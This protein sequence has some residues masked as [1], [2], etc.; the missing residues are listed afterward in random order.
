MVIEGLM[1]GIFIAKLL[2]TAQNEKAQ[3]ESAVEGET[4]EQAKER[5]HRANYESMFTKS[6]MPIF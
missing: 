4:E 1:L 6:G 2:S 3:R 5:I